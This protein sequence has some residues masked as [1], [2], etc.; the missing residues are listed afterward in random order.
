MGLRQGR[1]RLEKC[2][3]RDN[4]AGAH[5]IEADCSVALEQNTTAAGWH[6][7]CA[8]ISMEATVFLSASTPMG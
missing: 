4:A 8:S 7:S 1:G 3:L 2:D 6:R 5:Q